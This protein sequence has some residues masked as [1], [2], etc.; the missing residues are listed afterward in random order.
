MFI[1]I[2]YLIVQ[3]L[4]RTSA[5]DFISLFSTK[6]SFGPA[7]LIMHE[8]FV[9]VKTDGFPSSKYSRKQ[10]TNFKTEFEIFIL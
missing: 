8:P 10:R 9:K 5:A 6:L 2:A 1:L 7:S 4:S 3:C